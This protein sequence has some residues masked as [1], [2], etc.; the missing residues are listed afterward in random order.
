MP[1]LPASCKLVRV[2]G[3]VFCSSK[4]NT[5]SVVHRLHHFVTFL[6]EQKNKK[7]EQRD[8]DDNWDDEQ[9]EQIVVGLVRLQSRDTVSDALA[10]EVTRQTQVAH[11]TQRRTGHVRT[12]PVI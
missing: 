9:S 7:S 3:Q 6:V 4:R 12:R 5:K 1:K 10:V 11:V 2:T 8:D